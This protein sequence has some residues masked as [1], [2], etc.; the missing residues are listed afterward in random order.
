MVGTFP[1]QTDVKNR[2]PDG[3]IRFAVVTVLATANG[4]FPVYARDLDAGSFTRN[5]W[6]PAWL[7]IADRLHRNAARGGVCR[8]VAVGSA[9]AGRPPRGHA[10]LGRRGAHP[11]LRV[12]FDRRVFTDG[13]SRVDVSVENMLDKTAP[14][15]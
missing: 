9:G 8:C 13:Q 7:Q 4:T 12:N 15:R 1:T 5:R 11:F 14:R 2:W 6:T 3:S 10:G